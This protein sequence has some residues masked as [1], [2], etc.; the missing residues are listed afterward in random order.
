MTAIRTVD[1]APTGSSYISTN[2]GPFNGL[3]AG[4]LEGIGS[5]IRGNVG[6]S[7]GLSEGNAAMN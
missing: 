1:T 6:M 4:I 3:G 2:H 7:G 5:G